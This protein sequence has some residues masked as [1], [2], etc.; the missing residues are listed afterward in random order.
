M[1]VIQNSARSKQWTAGRSS[2]LPTLAFA[3]CASKF[4]IANDNPTRIVILS[5][6]RESKGLSSRSLP[7]EPSPASLPRLL[8]LLI[9]SDNPTRIVILSDQRESKGHSSRSLP[10]EPSLSSLPWLLSLLIANLE[11]EFRVFARKQTAAPKSNRKYSQLLRSPWRIAISCPQERR[12]YP[13]IRRDCPEPRRIHFAPIPRSAEG[14]RDARVLIG[15]LGISENELSCTKERRKQNPNRDKIAF[16]GNFA[17][18]VFSLQTSPASH[19]YNVAHRYQ[20]APFSDP[21]SSAP[22]LAII[23][24]PSRGHL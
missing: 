23:D 2:R 11:L 12:V 20:V 16:S 8:A 19:P 7:L 6:Q 4:L 5:D 17:S 10:L 14:A 9:A 18:H 1:I 24:F 22:N 15:T 21:L 13:E 3:Q